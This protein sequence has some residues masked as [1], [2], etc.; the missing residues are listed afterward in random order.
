MPYE[1]D[2]AAANEFSSVLTDV[3]TILDQFGDHCLVLGGDFNA[4]FN[5]HKKHSRLLQD[6]CGV[7]DLRVATLHNNCSIDFTYN[8]NMSRFSFSDYFIVSENVYASFNDSCSVRHDGDNLSD[9]DPIT[10]SLTI[11]WSIFDLVQRRYASKCKW[12]KANADDLLSYK[13][14]LKRRLTLCLYQ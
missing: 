14:S 1:S 4:D 5:E 7:N 11:D 2:A 13:R 8:F 12:H 3:I 6:V 9:H 10:L